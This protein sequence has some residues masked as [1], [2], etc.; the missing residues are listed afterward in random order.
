MLSVISSGQ[1]AKHNLSTRN[2]I[3][4]TH[5]ANSNGSGSMIG[6]VIA[7][8]NATETSSFLKNSTIQSSLRTKGNL[9]KSIQNAVSFVQTQQ[10]KMGMLEDIY[11]RMTKLAGNAT[12]PFLDEQLRTQYASEFQALKKV[13]IDIGKESFQGKALFDEM[14]AKYFPPIDYGAGFRS[15][16]S[17]T[18][19]VHN[20]T[21]PSSERLDGLNKYYEVEKEV[22]FDKGKFSLEVN[23]GATGERYMLKQ[24]DH[25]IFDTAGGS[26][27][28]NKWATYGNA[29]KYDFDKFE[30]EYS[31]G[32][33]TTFKFV[34][35][36]AGNVDEIKVPAEAAPDNSFDNKGF[37]D[38]DGNASGYIEQLGIGSTDGDKTSPWNA[39]GDNTETVY[40]GEVGEVKTYPA[41]AGETKLTLRVEANTI[42]QVKA[43]YTNLN[44]PESSFQVQVGEGASLDLAPV[45][46]GL[47]LVNSNLDSAED[48]GEALELLENE[49][50]SV[51]IQ[52]GTIGANLS[53]LE[54]ASEHIEN[55]VI[56]GDSFENTMMDEASI[57]RQIE[58]AKS[59][60]MLE[61]SR[62]LLAKAINTTRNIVSLLF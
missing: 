52:M 8:S 26:Y 18:L 39:G 32:K 7:G 10:S 17:G 45:G 23:G 6:G 2:L 19:I 37:T 9:S 15:D 34:P 46:V 27:G 55:Q 1:V 61:G 42:F 40:S 24:G 56:A 11:I 47:S 38:N 25:I 14:A 22:Y 30:I 33:P 4:R 58:S 51:S 29:W 12:D 21:V 57:D 36:S 54:V 50:E 28:D 5:G 31:P 59:G 35:Q 41:I 49:M 44:N 62:T 43:E 53:K 3:K 60:I 20:G 48:A 16:D 13:S